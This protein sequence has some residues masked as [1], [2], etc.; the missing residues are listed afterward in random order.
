MLVSLNVDDMFNGPQQHK[1]TQEKSLY[2]F[3]PLVEQ[4][5]MMD[6]SH[7]FAGQSIKKKSF[8][9]HNSDNTLYSSRI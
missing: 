8:M 7:S 2:Q 5:N 4:S 3:P 9:G 1:K 6:P